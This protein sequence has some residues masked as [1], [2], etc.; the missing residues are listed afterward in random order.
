[1]TTR[2]IE[3]SSADIDA[4]MRVMGDAF[5][6]AFGEAWTRSQCLGILGL[7]GVWLTI[8]YVGE[9]PGGFAL[10]RLVADEAELLLIG[11][12]SAFRRVGI[13][14]ALI[15]R[16]IQIAATGGAI[17]LHLE[18]RAGNSAINLYHKAG[19]T[20]IGRRKSYYRGAD[21]QLY[22][23]LTLSMDLNFLKQ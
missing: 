5:D 9:E 7:P 12:R 16:T 23:A 22:D 8:A 18:V 14:T 15:E 6:P 3:G 10:S 19:F 4:V 1:M 11:V 20:E 2:L 13:A 17:R 21:G